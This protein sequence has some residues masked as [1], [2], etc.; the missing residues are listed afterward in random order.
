MTRIFAGLCLIALSLTH[1]VSAAERSPEPT[2][3]S[4]KT[5]EYVVYRNNKKIGQ[6]SITFE[7]RNGTLVVT[8]E[9]RMR[10]KFLFITAYRYHYFSQETWQDG[11]LQSINTL[12]NDNGDKINTA[13]EMR[14][15]SFIAR[16]GSDLRTIAAPIFTTNH[17]N[18]RALEQPAL[19]NTITGKM[20]TIVVAAGDSEF[21]NQISGDLNINTYYD[22]DGHWL[23]MRFRH[24]DGS[25]IEFRC[26]R[27]RNTPGLSS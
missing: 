20:N 12:V 25:R 7:D 3:S 1:A 27:C 6:H 15:S 18:A 26:V 10:V 21:E 23:G 14:G 11:V 17:W 16:S 5:N 9:T 22:T 2:E 8:A 4:T 24:D 13:A 19:Y